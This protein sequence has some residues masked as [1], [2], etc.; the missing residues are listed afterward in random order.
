MIVVFS[1]VCACLWDCCHVKQNKK[2]N[3]NKIKN[4]IKSDCL[5]KMRMNPKFSDLN[6]EQKRAIAGCLSR[7][8]C[9]SL[10]QGPPGTGKTKTIIAMI[11][12]IFNGIGF[13]AGTQPKILVCAPSNAAID[14][15]I[16][17]FFVFFLFNF[18]CVFCIFWQI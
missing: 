15:V 9:I 13:I 8:E 12:A 7:N 2:T 16:P 11:Q 1:C 14:E 4:A 3:K 18:L 10:I 5:R 17:W 6:E